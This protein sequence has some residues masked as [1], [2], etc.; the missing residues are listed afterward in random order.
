MKKEICGHCKFYD[1][2]TGGCLHP[3]SILNRMEADE[4]YQY[5]NCNLFV[6]VINQHK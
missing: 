1:L 4:I 3:S 6:N 5:P 2:F